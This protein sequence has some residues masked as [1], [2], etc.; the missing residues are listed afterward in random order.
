MNN[1]SHKGTQNY[2]HRI[3][4]KNHQFSPFS[5]SWLSVKVFY[6]KL[7]Y[8]NLLFCDF[9]LVDAIPASKVLQIFEGN[10]EVYL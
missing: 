1:T 2:N 3:A 5:T 4:E 8:T 9:H 7:P 6:F 10:Y